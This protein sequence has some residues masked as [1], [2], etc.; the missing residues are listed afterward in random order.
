MIHAL[1]AREKMR[2]DAAIGR[3]VC[4]CKMH[5]TFK[6]NF[7]RPPGARWLEWVLQQVPSNNEH[8]GIVTM[9][10]TPTAPAPSGV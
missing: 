2:Y 7:H 10:T 3:V 1:F 5:A 8:S 6:R 9:G 4:R